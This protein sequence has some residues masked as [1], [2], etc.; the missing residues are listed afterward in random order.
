MEIEIL[1][2]TAKKGDKEALV[3]LIMLQKQDYYKLA[4]ALMKNK[5]DALDAMEDMIVIIYEN[6]YQL[7]KEEAFY[8]WSKR[9]LVNCCKKLLKTKNKVILLDTIKEEVYEENLQQKEDRM[10]LEEHLSQLNEKHQEVIRLRYFL[11]LD[12][13]TIADLLKVPLGTVKSRISIGLNKL[14]ESFGGEENERN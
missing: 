2:K 11:D 9:I 8:S 5:E 4:Y 7:K 1:I 14:K 10:L 12:Y 13:K 6:I 3:K